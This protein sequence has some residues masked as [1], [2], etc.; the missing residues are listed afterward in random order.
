MALIIGTN[1]TSGLQNSATSF[2]SSS[3]SPTA[4]TLIIATVWQIVG[5]GTPNNCTLS[6]A[7]MTWTEVGN[8][9]SSDNKQRITVFRALSSSPGSGAVTSANGSQTVDQQYSFNQFSNVD[10]SGSNGANAIVQSLASNTFSGTNTGVTVTLS[11]FSNANNATF[12]FVA[13]SAQP[14]IVAGS[15]FTELSQV[16]TESQAQWKN[17]ND[18]SVDWTWPSTANIGIG[19]ALELKASNDTGAGFFMNFV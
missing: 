5:S 18:T 4:N 13:G 8:V 10:V 16:A 11:A 3:I 14:G 2:T 19:V 1:L 17:S 15:G 9:L 12:G 6:G 7:G